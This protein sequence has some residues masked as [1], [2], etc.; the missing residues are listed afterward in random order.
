MSFEDRLSAAMDEADQQLRAAFQSQLVA[1]ARRAEELKLAIHDAPLRYRNDPEF[2]AKV[3]T[4]LIVLEDTTPMAVH[5][6]FE[7]IL[8]LES[9]EGWR[10]SS[11]P[12]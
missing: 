2:H 1:D 12:E 9:L 6:A 7:I 11:Q 5:R 3:R 10:R 4:V 8:R